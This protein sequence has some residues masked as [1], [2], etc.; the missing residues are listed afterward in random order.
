VELYQDGALWI[1]DQEDPPIEI[2]LDNQ[3]TQR[4]R[5]FLMRLDGQQCKAEYPYQQPINAAPAYTEP[6]SYQQ[7]D[8]SPENQ[9]YQHYQN[10][11]ATLWLFLIW[12]IGMY[13]MWKHASWST[14]TKIMI[15]ALFAVLALLWL[16]YT[17]K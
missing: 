1:I 11:R 9:K 4:L 13:L 3:A 5:D 12:P 6:Q 16:M 7:I 2:K 10:E 14:T 17:H 8:P 15:S